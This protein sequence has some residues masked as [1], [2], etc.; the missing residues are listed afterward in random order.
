MMINIETVSKRLSLPPRT[1][2]GLIQRGELKAYKFGK[3]FRVYETDL[4]A[5]IKRCAI[6]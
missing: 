1:V 2:R 4:N 6:Q 5:Y 3:E